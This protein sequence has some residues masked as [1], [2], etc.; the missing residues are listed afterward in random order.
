VLLVDPA[1]HAL[2]EPGDAVADDD[3]WATEH[4]DQF[5]ALRNAGTQVRII[6]HSTGGKS[7]RVP[8]PLPLG[9][10]DVVAA[11]TRVLGEV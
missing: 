2:R 4:R 3:A 11:V 6:A 9:H 10:P 1:A 5:V 7:D 8:P